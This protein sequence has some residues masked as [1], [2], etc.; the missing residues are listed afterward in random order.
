MPRVVTAVH[1]PV[2]LAT[3][4]ELL[5]L[6]PLVGRV[7]RLNAGEVFAWVIRLGAGR[8]PVVCGTLTGLIACRPHGNAFGRYAHL[9]HFIERYYGLRP[10][11]RR[12]QH[13]RG[14]IK[15]RR[16]ARRETA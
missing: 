14:V 1:D 16:V 6:P 9:M 5:G 8:H 3:L 13:C 2:A 7:T 15:G 10:G 11:L 12:G 4:C